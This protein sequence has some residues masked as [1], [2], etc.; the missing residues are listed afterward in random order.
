MFC[1]VWNHG[2]GGGA[3]IQIDKVFRF[4]QGGGIFS[5]AQLL[6]PMQFHAQGYLF[7]PG[8]E[9]SAVLYRSSEYFHQH[10]FFV[11]Y[12]QIP[13]DRGFGRLEIFGQFLDGDASLRFH[14]LYNLFLSFFRKHRFHR[15]FALFPFQNLCRLPDLCRQSVFLNLFLFLFYMKKAIRANSRRWCR[16]PEQS[17]TSVRFQP[18]GRRRCRRGEP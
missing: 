10:A 17:G 15:G 4:D 14:K 2:A 5:D 13:P 12:V 11:Q 8:G 16:Q 7:F 1:Q 6:F 9:F 3:G 18:L